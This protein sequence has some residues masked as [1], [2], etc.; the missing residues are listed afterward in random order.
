M[1]LTF[2]NL[3]RMEPRTPTRPITRTLTKVFTTAAT[4]QGTGPVLNICKRTTIYHRCAESLWKLRPGQSLCER[5]PQQPLRVQRFV[6]LSG[7]PI[8]SFLIY[9]NQPMMLPLLQQLVLPTQILKISPTEALKNTSQNLTSSTHRTL[10]SNKILV[11]TDS[12]NFVYPS[13]TPTSTRGLLATDLVI[14]NH[15][16]VTRTTP[17]L[18][19][20]SPNY[21]I[22]STGER[23]LGYRGHHLSIDIEILE[24]PTKNG[25]YGNQLR[26]KRGELLGLIVRQNSRFRTA[27]TVI[28][29]FG[30][31]ASF[32][33]LESAKN[34][35][36]EFH[37][38]TGTMYA[39]HKS[40][41]LRLVGVI[42]KN[43]YEECDVEWNGKKSLLTRRWSL[44]I[45]GHWNAKRSS[46][47]YLTYWALN[48]GWPAFEMVFPYWWTW[49]ETVGGAN[50]RFRR[51]QKKS[52]P[53]SCKQTRSSSAIGRQESVSENSIHCAWCRECN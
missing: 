24:S 52:S 44:D 45:F 3:L 17:E 38:L 21:H 16:Q 7:Q 12:M 26:G 2:D 50:W 5:A 30:L 4:C 39:E 49:K 37:I 19:P 32:V 1:D 14:L 33:D 27:K 18:A 48:V 35:L 29:K 9:C 15:A 13:R 36:N 42:H 40:R 25:F 47:P 22:T 41:K 43:S 8:E 31:D 20:P 23:L 51:S 6:V 28:I 34:S 46:V 11:S 53:N 10:T